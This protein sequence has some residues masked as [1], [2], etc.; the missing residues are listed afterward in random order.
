[1]QM[2]EGLDTGD[3]AM[4][5][6]LPIGPDMTAGELHDAL[7]PLG[8]DLMA[9]ALDGLARGALSSTPQPE[10]GVTYA[11]KIDKA[12]TRI[13][14]SKPGARCTT[15]SAA[16]RRFPAPGS[17]WDGV[18]VKVRAFDARRG[19]RRRPASLLDDRLTIAC[20]DGAV[21]LVEVAARRQAADAGRRIHARHADRAGH[22]TDM[23]PSPQV[24]IRDERPERCGGRPIRDRRCVRRS[25]GRPISSRGCAPPAIWCW[26]WWR[27][28]TTRS[29]AISP[30]RAS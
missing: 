17:N 24:A 30:G 22:A 27:S 8:A 7:A 28:R 9:A 20:G 10:A 25:G 21:R 4:T 15:T 2:D 29:S 19:Q 16:C 3:V 6:A 1:M 5:R 23:T 18:R 13:D 26:R 14:W 11:E 12:E